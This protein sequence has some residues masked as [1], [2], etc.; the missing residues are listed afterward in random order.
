MK[1]HR[2]KLMHLK[3]KVENR[4]IKSLEVQKK[5]ELQE[6]RR[7]WLT[8]MVNESEEAQS[9]PQVPTYGKPD[10]DEDELACL[11]LP[12]NF[13]SYQALDTGDLKFEAVSTHTKGRWSRMATGSPQDY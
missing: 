3:K 6:L 11:A 12:V 8:L 2:E 1:K 4:V 13:A 7:A 5:E 9:V 10:L